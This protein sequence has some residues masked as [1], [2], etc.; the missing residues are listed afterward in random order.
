M[1]S[2]PPAGGSDGGPEVDQDARLIEFG[3][4][5]ERAN[6]L[7][8]VVKRLPGQLVLK[9][10][11][12]ARRNHL[13]ARWDEIEIPELDGVVPDA[14]LNGLKKWI[15][16]AEVLIGHIVNIGRGVGQLKNKG[17]DGRIYSGPI[18]DPEDLPQ[19]INAIDEAD[20]VSDQWCWPWA[21]RALATR[22]NKSGWNKGKLVKAGVVAG[23]GLMAVLT[24]LEEE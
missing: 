20:G 14:S 11:L 3:E 1:K 22:E 19:V 9:S 10:G 23:L 4:L 18:V 24:Y 6:E 2:L 8:D 21:S 16:D 12:S 5:W 15:H 17:T 7:H 13:F